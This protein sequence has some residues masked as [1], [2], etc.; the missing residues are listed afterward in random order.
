M[1]DI[2]TIFEVEDDSIRGSSEENSVSNSL[3]NA[4]KKSKISPTV[5]I[6]SSIKRK[7]EKDDACPS[8]LLTFGG[9]EG[10]PKNE[11]QSHKEF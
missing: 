2:G 3:S 1:K 9:K 4:S 7:E 8:G 6:N 5:Q 10:A 11:F